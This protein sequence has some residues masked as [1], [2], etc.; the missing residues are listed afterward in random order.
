[1]GRYDHRIVIPPDPTSVYLLLE[2]IRYADARIRRVTRAPTDVKT[3]RF[4][5]DLWCTGSKKGWEQDKRRAES[6]G[7]K[8]EEGFHN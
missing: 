8:V 1:M 4:I 5:V 3:E 7:L 6:I 2:H